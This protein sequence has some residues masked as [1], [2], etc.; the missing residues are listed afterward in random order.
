MNYKRYSVCILYVIICVSIIP[1]ET[2]ALLSWRD[3]LAEAGVATQATKVKVIVD[4]NMPPA[5]FEKLPENVKFVPDMLQCADASQRS[6]GSKVFSEY[7]KN[8]SKCAQGIV[9][10]T[11]LGQKVSHMTT[12]I[13]AVNLILKSLQT[14]KAYADQLENLNG[15]VFGLIPFGGEQMQKYEQASAISMKCI[16]DIESTQK[17]LAPV[18]TGGYSQ[19]PLYIGATV[20]QSKAI[21]KLKTEAAAITKYMQ[22]EQ[23]KS[24]DGKLSTGAAMSLM[25]KVMGLKS[26]GEKYLIPIIPSA[27]VENQSYLKEEDMIIFGFSGNGETYKVPGAI[28]FVLS[29]MIDLGKEPL[30]GGLL[31][32]DT[33]QFT[34]YIPE[35]PMIEEFRTKIDKKIKEFTAKKIKY[36]EQMAKLQGEFDALSKKGY[37]CGGAELVSSGNINNPLPPPPPPSNSLLK[38]QASI[39]TAKT[40]VGSDENINI[41]FESPANT[42]R[43]SVYISCPTG[44]SSLA[45]GFE[46]NKLISLGKYFNSLNASFINRTSKVQKVNMK[47]YA[48][49]SDREESIESFP[50]VISVNPR[51]VPPPAVV[52]P[53]YTPS[54][55]STPSYSPSSIPT[56]STTPTYTSAPTYYSTPTYSSTP[57]VSASSSSSPSPTITTSPTPTVSSTPTY[58]PS[59]STSPSSSPSSSASPSLS[60]ISTLPMISNQNASLWDAIVEWF[61][62]F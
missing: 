31:T 2:N 24:K 11:V 53:T 48:Y 59:Y 12:S 60:P 51:V 40:S 8:R 58:N 5:E 42:T 4:N 35:K 22:E 7:V 55:T 1:K 29:A 45:A 20:E 38:S 36:E 44:V 37:S 3:L 9:D 21:T 46:C 47:F 23:T 56:Y 19:G 15:V 17:I 13:D 52:T 54:Y 26:E 33:Q 32:F 49:T 18:G 6:G 14:T 39:S 28:K 30:S 43:T 57:T 10:A 25:S 27:I 34:L 61:K 62:S 41:K 50:L 16:Q